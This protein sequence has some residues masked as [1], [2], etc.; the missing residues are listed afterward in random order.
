MLDPYKLKNIRLG[1]GNS[2]IG[3]VYKTAHGWEIKIGEVEL[4][5]AGRAYFTP[6]DKPY[7]RYPASY[8]RD[9]AGNIHINIS[10]FT[11]ASLR[12]EDRMEK[13][14]DDLFREPFKD[15]ELSN[16]LLNDKK[17]LFRF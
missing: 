5:P 10:S 17:R 1:A 3:D 11:P 4:E 15:S 16:N 9:L 6:A 12:I 8:S 13:L 7:I 14:I 2:L